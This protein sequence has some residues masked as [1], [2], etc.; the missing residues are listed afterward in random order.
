[1]QAYDGFLD[2]IEIKRPEG[3]PT[4]WADKLDH[5][6]S[7]PSSDLTKAITQVSRYI[8]EVEREAN[9]VKF[10]E[11]VDHVKTI[12]PRCILIFGRSN[13]WDSERA[14]SYRILNSSFHNL[15]I[16]TYDHVLD[17]ARRLLKHDEESQLEDS[18]DSDRPADMPF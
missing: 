5:G 2:V 14:E 18:G 1:M 9:S 11:R 4:F 17:R 10:L 12:K 16:L 7:V 6:N 13:N 3:R 8:Y 15:T